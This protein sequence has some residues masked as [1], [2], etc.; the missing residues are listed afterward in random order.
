MKTCSPSFLLTWARNSINLFRPAWM[1]R[2]G[3]NVQLGRLVLCYAQKL[4]PSS[5]LHLNSQHKTVDSNT[6]VVRRSLQFGTEIHP[7]KT[8]SKIFYVQAYQC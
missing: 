2:C 1:V 5:Q 7:Q 6:T 4:C 8:R 3:G